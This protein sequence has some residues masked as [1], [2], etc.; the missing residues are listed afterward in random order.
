EQINLIVQSVRALLRRT[1][2]RHLVMRNTDVNALVAAVLRLAGPSLDAHGIEG[3]TELAP[4]VPPGRADY[5][6]LHQV[7]LNLV[8]NSVD[9]MQS[10]GRLTLRT[11][12]D[13]AGLSATLAVRD[14]GI[15]IRP[16]EHEH[17]FEPTWTTKPTGSGFGLAIAREIIDAHAGA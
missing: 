11:E 3:V 12:V 16:E 1:H 15:G 4:A 10:G 6:S 2:K 7:L 17:L 9:A 8:N 13:P 5:D 14:T